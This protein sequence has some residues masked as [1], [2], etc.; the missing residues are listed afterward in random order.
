MHS[1]TVWRDNHIK[2]QQTFAALKKNWK[3]K[4]RVL[5]LYTNIQVT[6]T[7]LQQ[8]NLLQWG[9]KRVEKHW[10]SGGALMLNSSLKASHIKILVE[11]EF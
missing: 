2:R 8:T 6:H 9:R 3:K 7:T 10:Y 1:R 5:Q 4:I 11:G